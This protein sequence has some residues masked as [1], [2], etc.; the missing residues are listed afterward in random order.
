MLFHG[1]P[2]TNPDTRDLVSIEPYVEK[3]SHYIREYLPCLDD[4]KPAILESC[5]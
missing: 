4:R 1:G 3:V 2:E 5:M